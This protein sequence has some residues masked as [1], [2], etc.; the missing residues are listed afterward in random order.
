MTTPDDSHSS[1]GCR[2][3]SST[4]HNRSDR[5]RSLSRIPRRRESTRPWGNH[6]ENSR[7]R[8]RNTTHLS[9]G[10]YSLTRIGPRET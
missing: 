4:S 7:V 2:L 1:R 9:L 8:N 6:L 10:A 3:R 5:Y